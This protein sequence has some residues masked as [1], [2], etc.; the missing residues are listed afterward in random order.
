MRA[1]IE[2]GADGCPVDESLTRLFTSGHTIEEVV[3]AVG[4]Y[5]SANYGQHRVSEGVDEWTGDKVRVHEFVTGGWSGCEQI[6]S[7][8][9]GSVAGILGWESSHRGGL[10]VYRF[11]PDVMNVAVDFSSPLRLNER[12]EQ[13]DRELTAARQRIAALEGMLTEAG[14]P[15]PAP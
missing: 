7:L 11:A 5:F 6:V 13:K 8:M 1:H 12:D 10:H 4:E 14:I 15:V 3:S 9:E 2:V